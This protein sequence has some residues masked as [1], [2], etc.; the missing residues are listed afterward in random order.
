MAHAVERR[1]RSS[2]KGSLNAVAVVSMAGR[3]ASVG[4]Q[5]DL[6]RHQ[7]SE[8]FLAPRVE[9]RGCVGRVP[10]AGRH[11]APVARALVAGQ[12]SRRRIDAVEVGEPKSVTQLVAQGSDFDGSVGR[13]VAAQRGRDVVVVDFDEAAAVARV[14]GRVRKPARTGHAEYVP[15]VRLDVVGQAALGAAEAVHDAQHVDEAVV[16]AGVGDTV[17]AVVVVL[18][19]VDRRRR[20]RR[21]LP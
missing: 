13:C 11:D 19:E 9:V 2:V 4:C 1:K 16:V 20:S 10:V 18:G 5:S 6:G 8:L 3:F 17:G 12:A 21:A 15:R 14:V 7:P